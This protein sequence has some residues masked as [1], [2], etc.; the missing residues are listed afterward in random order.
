M[1]TTKFL[2]PVACLALVLSGCDDGKKKVD[3]TYQGD[4]GLTYATETLTQSQTNAMLTS[5]DAKEHE[6]WEP[7]NLENYKLLGKETNGSGVSQRFYADDIYSST[8]A[9]QGLFLLQNDEGYVGFFT[10]IT[11][12]WILKPQFIPNTFTYEVTQINEYIGILLELRYEEQYILYDVLGNALVS[13]SQHIDLTFSQEYLNVGYL[14]EMELTGIDVYFYDDDYVDPDFPGAIPGMWRTKYFTYSKNGALTQNTMSWED[15]EPEEE[16]E[17]T[18]FDLPILELDDYGY[19]GYYVMKGANGYSAFY[20]RE[21]DSGIGQYIGSIYDQDVL[22][23]FR[24][25]VGSKVMF[26][27]WIELPE[28]TEDYDFSVGNTK[29]SLETYSYDMNDNFKKETYNFKFVIGGQI[30]VVALKVE[31]HN[32]Y[33][34]NILEI[35]GRKVL[36]PQET[37]II[38]EEMIVVKN[39]TGVTPTQFEK[40]GESFYN[41]ESKILFSSNMEPIA[42]FVDFQSVQILREHELFLVRYNNLYGLVD[43]HGYFMYECEYSDIYSEQGIDG[44]FIARDNDTGDLHSIGRYEGMGAYVNDYNTISYQDGLFW[45]SYYN[46]GD[47][48]RHF[49]TAQGNIASMYDDIQS[50]QVI[51][52]FG[53][54]MMYGYQKENM[55]TFY[56]TYTIVQDSVAFTSTSGTELTD[57]FA[58]QTLTDPFVL[59]LGENKLHN[60]LGYTYV[61]FTPTEDGYYGIHSD[62]TFTT[63]GRHQYVEVITEDPLVTEDKDVVIGVTNGTIYDSFDPEDNHNVARVTGWEMKA[64]HTYV[65]NFYLNVPTLCT[66]TVKKEHAHT[67]ESWQ[68]NAMERVL[69]GSDDVIRAGKC[70]ECNEV[71][72]ELAPITYEVIT[73]TAFETELA[74]ITTTRSYYGGLN[75][76]VPGTLDPYNNPV[77]IYT[78]KPNSEISGFVTESR[79]PANLATGK[80][81]D[82]FTV[83]VQKFYFTDDTDK[84]AIGYSVSCTKIVGGVTTTYGYQVSEDGLML[85]E[86]YMVIGGYSEVAT[87]EVNYFIETE[88]EYKAAYESYQQNVVNP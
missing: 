83:T 45:T 68:I 51:K 88:A 71:V 18:P 11:N 12:D 13:S 23:N 65:L 76:D 3:P 62:Y 63:T 75:V 53:R 19:E 14:E 6:E 80:E 2:L 55:Y 87:Y 17:L 32:F 1:K 57:P 67:V 52:L 43:D 49:F 59:S 34:M 42:S 41:K 21:K 5:F 28:R 56:D 48:T 24:G 78:W 37:L 47:Y 38:N 77:M 70:T 81:T 31:E 33:S 54:T 69:I 74:A 16:E 25:M 82:G 60:I 72:Y 29:Y 85:S 7:Q 8:Y 66:L 40:V 9:A 73:A 10:T 84:A 46:S 39:M 35:N 61:S 22:G 15:L 27:R 30:K 36:E 64:N 26:Q 58:A 79:F 20:K 50:F 4:N 86:S 44:A